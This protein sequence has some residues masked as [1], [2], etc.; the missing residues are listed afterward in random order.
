MKV[1]EL[2]SVGFGS[3]ELPSRVRIRLSQQGYAGTTTWR[4]VRAITRFLE[5]LPRQTILAS[6]DVE[7]A[8]ARFLDCHLPSCRCR[9]RCPERKTSR[10]ALGHM[11]RIMRSDGHDRNRS[12]SLDPVEEKLQGFDGYLRDVC[13]LSEAT[14][15]QRRRIVRGFLRF[16]FDNMAAIDDANLSQGLAA[17]VV[18]SAHPRTPGS[19]AAVA[20][21]LRSYVRYLQF[22]GDV[23]PRHLCAIPVPPKIALRDYPRLLS[24]EQ[25]KALMSSFDTR[26]PSGM[27]DHAMALCMLGMGLRASEVA[28]IDLDDIDWRVSVLH[29][30]HGKSRVVR[31]LPVMQ[32]CGKSIAR[33]LRAGRPGTDSRRLFVRHVVPAGSAMNAENVRGAMRRAYARAGFSS[34][35]TGTHILR[36]TA[37]TNMLN[38]GSTL[39]EIADVL[40]HQSIDTTMGYTKVHTQ[41]LRCV[42][43]PWPGDRQ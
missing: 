2:L 8:I 26:S 10:A 12:C 9:P 14:R 40:G 38:G 36:H 31:D 4:Y 18:S 42:V 32:D 20:T 25:C 22:R 24:R 16:L 27:R 3:W 13:G 1:T 17:Y 28:G 29:L 33:Y 11:K 30:R 34:E 7:T 21:G 6:A 19:M 15:L 41:A 35:V 5:W 23:D 39:K 43:Q 37:A